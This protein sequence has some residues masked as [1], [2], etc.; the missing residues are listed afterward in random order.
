VKEQNIMRKTD[1]AKSIVY[2]RFVNEINSSELNS[3]V[4]SCIKS[5]ELDC[6]NFLWIIDYVITKN[7]STLLVIKFSYKVTMNSISSKYLRYR[8]IYI[9]TKSNKIIESVD[10]ES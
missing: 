6:N 5:M 3:I 2:P 9:D 10:I 7:T 4:D 8:E 1:N